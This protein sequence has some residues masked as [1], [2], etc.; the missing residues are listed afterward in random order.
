MNVKYQIHTLVAAL[1]L[2]CGAAQVSA[3]TIVAPGSSQD[4][5]NK[6]LRVPAATEVR[7]V[8]T[9][10]GSIAIENGAQAVKVATVNGSIRVGDEVSLKS[11]ETVN[12]SVTAGV[13]LR[14]TESVE[15]VNGRIELGTGSTVGG[16][17]ET[18]NG[19]IA[20]DRV[21]IGGTVSTVNG[22]ILLNG[23]QVGG[24]VEMVNGRSELMAGTVVAGD[25]IVRQSKR[26]GWGWSK[27]PKPPVVVIGEGSEV[28]GRLLIEN[29]DTEVLIHQNARVGKVEGATPRRY[30]GEAPEV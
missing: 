8:E 10:N 9:V 7:N 2:S 13:N 17:V 19:R 25:V 3:A 14:V 6:S 18:V 27:R 1:L 11:L 26:I 15:T 30:S 24:N 28:R 16:A 23:S 20:G 4:S 12:G 5:V 21:G 29:P 22:Q